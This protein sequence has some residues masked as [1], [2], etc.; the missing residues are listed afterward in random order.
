MKK[1]AITWLFVPIALAAAAP[2]G[3]GPTIESFLSP[4]YP[5][6]IVSA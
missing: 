4:G 2:S 1:I 6:E 3:T 5:T